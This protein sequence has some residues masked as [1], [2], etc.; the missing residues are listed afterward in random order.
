M[1]CC[2]LITPRGDTAES[3]RVE[4]GKANIKRK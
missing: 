3:A 2:V 1:I 4:K